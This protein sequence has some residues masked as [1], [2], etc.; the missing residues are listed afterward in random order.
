MVSSNLGWLQKVI[1][2]QL[3][4]KNPYGFI[5]FRM[6]QNCLAWALEYL[7]MCHQSRKEIIIWKLDFKKN[8]W[9]H[10]APNNAKHHETQRLWR[11]MVSLDG[12]YFLLCYF[13]I[14]NQC[15]SWE[16]FSL[17]KRDKAG[18]PPPLFLFVLTAA[19]LQN[20]INNARA[21]GH[22]TMPIPLQYSQDFPVLQYADDT[23][24]ITWFLN[25]HMS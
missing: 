21:H 18:R 9:K 3:I 7:H 24:V 20:V 10:W 5:Q 6:I 19:L 8:I 25:F 16:G 13:I 14:P 23:M 11:K 12:T 22:L 15:C 2:Q 17:Q 4:H 1:H